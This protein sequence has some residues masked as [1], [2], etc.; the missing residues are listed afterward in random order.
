V[1]R[2]DTEPY[3]VRAPRRLT[4]EFVSISVKSF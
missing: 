3:M 4:Q 1:A 2:W